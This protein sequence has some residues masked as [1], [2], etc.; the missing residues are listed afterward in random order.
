ML[1][2]SV[3]TLAMAQ[4]FVLATRDNVTAGQDSVATI[5]AAQKLE[6]LRAP[7]SPGA[8]GAVPGGA[9]D[10]SVPGYVDHVGPGGRVVG[11]AAVPPASALYTRRW[12]IESAPA[13]GATATMVR[14]IV[15][16]ARRGGPRRPVWAGGWPGTARVVSIVARRAS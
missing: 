9:L 13:A 7:V 1:V 4:L 10:A 12:S 3:G 16:P 15:M 2:A 14:V 6:E 5:L 11:V 8:P